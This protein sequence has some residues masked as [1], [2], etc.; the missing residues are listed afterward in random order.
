[1][2]IQVVFD[3]N[4]IKNWIGLPIENFEAM[5][6]WV[7][8]NIR[9]YFFIEDSNNEKVFELILKNDVLHLFDST[10]KFISVENIFTEDDYYKICN[11]VC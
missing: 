1:M 3:K 11:G 9:S 10:G 5:Y 8:Q 4:D 2:I 7:P 6:Q